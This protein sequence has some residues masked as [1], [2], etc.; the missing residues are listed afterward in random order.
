MFEGG[1]SFDNLWVTVQAW[2]LTT[3]VNILIA[4]V[5][6]GVGIMLAYMASRL[7]HKLFAKSSI[8]ASFVSFLATTVRIAVGVL[9]AIT[10]LSQ[11]G[12][13][14]T[15]IITAFASCAVAIGLAMQSSLSNIAGGMF[16]LITR[17]ILTGDLTEVDG[18]VA[19]VK[20]IDIVATVFL[21]PDNSQII[22]PNGQ[23]INKTIINYSREDIR[24]LDLEVSIAYT[25]DIAKAKRVISEVLD[26]N[27]LV[28]DTPAPIIGVS[29]HAASAVTIALRPWC[30]PENF[31]TLRAELLE[32]IKL[33]FDANRIEIPYSKL[34]VYIN[35]E[36]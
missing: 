8:D 18:R 27:P 1:F 34:D 15:S 33:A 23:L 3:G 20:K 25:A 5:I 21:T 12:I 22:I 16:L 14:T 17:P 19:T 29:G 10:A 36:D 31:L 32:E 9:A 26:R 4:L 7:I 11:L 35:K 28:L 6:L 13:P 30:K 24:R 2:L